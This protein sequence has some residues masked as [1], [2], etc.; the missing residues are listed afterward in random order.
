MLYNNIRHL[1]KREAIYC[2]TA[3]LLVSSTDIPTQLFQ[4]LS[5]SLSLSF[6]LV[7]ISTTDLYVI[8]PFVSGASLSIPIG[9][10]E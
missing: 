1:T 6:S 9:M 5:F 4:F 3:V 10:F 8:K 2:K 7:S